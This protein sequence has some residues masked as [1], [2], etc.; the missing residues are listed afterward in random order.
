MLPNHFFYSKNKEHTSYS[1]NAPGQLN[2]NK[3]INGKPCWQRSA[4]NNGLEPKIFVLYDWTADQWTE[5]QL[6]DYISKLNCLVEKGFTCYIWQKE[7]LIPLTKEK[8]ANLSAS[9]ERNISLSTSQN[10]LDYIEKTKKLQKHQV[11]LLDDYELEYLFTPENQ[12]PTRYLEL[13]KLVDYK[14]SNSNTNF[15]SVMKQATPPITIIYDEL[16]ELAD[17]FISEN[18]KKLDKF[19]RIENYTK[20]IFKN[21]QIVELT[22]NNTFSF[23]SAQYI[24]GDVLATTKHLGF[25]EI[26]DNAVLPQLLK[27]TPLLNKLEFDNQTIP[28][29]HTNLDLPLLE[30]LEVNGG[31]L[32]ADDLYKLTVHSNSLKTLSSLYSTIKGYCTQ[33]YHFPALESF[34]LL[35]VN[36]SAKVIEQILSQTPELQRLD[37]RNYKDTENYPGDVSVKINLPELVSLELSESNISKEL[38]DKILASTTNLKSLSIEGKEQFSAFESNIENLQ[39]IENLDIKNPHYKQGDLIAL[40]SKLPNL[41]QVTLSECSVDGPIP[42]ENIEFNSLEKIVLKGCSFDTEQL[43][44]ILAKAPN[45]KSVEITECSNIDRNKELNVSLPNLEELILDCQVNAQSLQNI[46]SQAHHLKYLKLGS[47]V[48]DE[49]INETFYLDSLQQFELDL[50]HNLVYSKELYQL[51]GNAPNIRSLVITKMV[52]VDEITQEFNLYLLE[53]LTLNDCALS[54]DS[55]KKLLAKTPNLKNLS[56]DNCISELTEDPELLQL[57]NKLNETKNA[58]TKKT[59]PININQSPAFSTMSV[60]ADTHYDP[61]ISYNIP[62]IFYPLD[63][64]DKIPEPN[65]YRQAVFGG[66][67]IS[68]TPCN[69]NKAFNL[70]KGPN[71]ALIPSPQSQACEEDVFAIGKSL[72]KEKETSYV[73]GKQ[74]LNISPEWQALTSLKPD[75]MLTHFHTDPKV[76][77]EI[78]YSQRD[79]QYYV[80]STSTQTIDIDFLLRIPKRTSLPST[81]PPQMQQYI[82][83]CNSFTQGPLIIEQPNPT[84][85][86]YLECIAKQK[87]G[88]CRHSAMLFK[89]LMQQNLPHIPVRIVNNDCHMYPEVFLEGRWHGIS[90]SGYPAQ[91]NINEANNPHKRRPIPT[92]TAPDIAKSQEEPTITHVVIDQTPEHKQWTQINNALETWKQ[93]VVATINA[94]ELSQQLTHNDEQKKHLVNIPD[95]QELEIYKLYLQKYCHS[96]NRPVFVINSPDDLVCLAPFVAH[97][98]ALGIMQNGPGG[99]LHD[100]LTAPVDKNNPPILIVNYNNFSREDII[101]FNEFLEGRA[102]GTPIPPEARI[103]GL[104]N[105]QKPDCYHGSDFTSRFDKRATYLK[106]T[107]ALLG[108]N[109][110]ETAEQSATIAEPINLYHS[111]NWEELL[112]GYWVIQ[113]NELHWSEGKL[114]DALK[115]NRPLEIQ[116]GPWQDE[117]FNRFWQQAFALGY[118]EHAGRKIVLPKNL[119]LRKVE[120]YDWNNAPITLSWHTDFKPGAETLNSTLFNTLFVRYECDKK[121]KALY[122]KNGLIKA[123][124]KQTLHVNLTHDLSEDEWAMLVD[125]CKKYQVHLVCHAAPCVILP[126]YLK[127]TLAPQSTSVP[128]DQCL[129][130]NPHTLIFASSDVDVTVKQF[131]DG[132]GDWQIIDVSECDASDLLF[133]LSGEFKKDDLRFEFN[134][135]ENALLKALKMN[136]RVILKGAFS[137]ELRDAL[138]PLLLER[139]STANPNGQLMIIS[140]LET[141]IQYIKNIPHQVSTEEKSTILSTK[142]TAEELKV[143]DGQP[144]E[145]E[146]LAILQA[147]LQSY[148]RAPLSST[149]KAWEGMNSLP[150]NLHTGDFDAEHSKEKA[151]AFIKKRKNELEIFL[152]Q[153]HNVCITGLTG[154]GKS[155]FVETYLNSANSKVFTDIHDWVTS[156]EPGR[157]V[158][159]RDEANITDADLSELEGLYNNPPGILVDG[160][161]F[162]LTSEHCVCAA[163]NPKNYSD[164][165]RLPSFFA[166]HGNA[167]VFEPMPQEY[168]YEYILKPVF[169]YTRLAEHSFDIA[170]QLLPIYSFLITHSHEEV[171]ISARELQMMALLVLQYHR[172]NPQADISKVAANYAYTIGKNLVPKHLHHQFDQ[173]FKPQEPLF[174]AYKAPEFL[175]NKFLMTPSR[176]QTQQKLNELIELH[177]FRRTRAITHQQM[178]G[179]INGMIL[180]G[181]PGIGKTQLVR[182]TL[183]AQGYHEALINQDQVPEYCYYRMPASMHPEEKKRLLLKAFDEGA[184]VVIDE[185]NSSLIMEQLINELLMGKTPEGKRPTSPGFMILG[186]QNPPSMGGRRELSNAVKRRFL[187]EV[188]P[189]YTSQEMKTILMH[190]GLSVEMANKL[191]NVYDQKVAEAQ[192]KNLFPAPNFRD[193]NKLAKQFITAAA[194]KKRMRLESSEIEEQVKRQKQEH[195][196]AQ[197][198][199]TYTTPLQ[200]IKGLL[201]DY[202]G[203][204]STHSPTFFKEGT[205]TTQINSLLRQKKINTVEEFMEQLNQ[206]QIP[207]SDKQLTSRIIFINNHILH[208]TAQ[209]MAMKKIRPSRLQ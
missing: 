59:E 123:H 44:T 98:G 3:F 119:K 89:A 131:A 197:L 76:D 84:G 167:L 9:I 85:F 12:R 53:D 101:R 11:L 187:H 26:Q 148:R 171:L 118:I 13:S 39:L 195:N 79:N 164:E 146:P 46:L 93:N 48:F 30:Y 1:F 154:V 170:Q 120:N 16:S 166:R 107:N 128:W 117:R 172:Q 31:Y 56:I 74:K 193:L 200:K 50:A 19:N 145:T 173:K 133:K 24:Q 55:L 108:Q 97:Q 57:I 96:I 99:R 47:E 36:V 110:F 18:Q 83:I 168:I 49:N 152:A 208:S 4:N 6:D 161:Y 198:C 29:F 32:S 105:P 126:E 70:Q 206:I 142:F 160:E 189:D 205:Y 180:E 25:T 190:Q 94:F 202:V 127:A 90:L 102:D 33:T 71:I 81:I 134:E 103:I 58:N 92:Q 122:S 196:Y 130:I 106:I 68:P 183:E 185:I 151:Q 8:I 64:K 138:A 100:F 86:D 175:D 113:G 72:P 159:F 28:N 78:A 34:S 155:T 194:S 121:Q 178:F 65:Y 43:A 80:R 157:K 192:A 2:V 37:L 162:P 60:D 22:Q 186:T 95:N 141:P 75:E 38:V 132:S 150:V 27:R 10:V 143:V 77:V 163:M 203:S 15:F 184:V 115:T 42:Q 188:L 207:A 87:K 21:K 88:A 165:R 45:L 182:E 139:L 199:E 209:D 204:Y 179:G 111:P 41:R 140:T 14:T 129:G 69:I 158:L 169:A 125:E 136:Q 137:Q 51:I 176:Q 61:N 82:E 116:N 201:T 109:Y 62:R 104:R 91:L 35:S 7:K 135:T 73:Y 54:V 177:R 63:P 191:V 174:N 156:K 114:V 5:K 181:V 23:A 153:E 67:S 144:L 20:I 40:L 124:A 17:E 149:D 52:L 147:R 112:L 66:F